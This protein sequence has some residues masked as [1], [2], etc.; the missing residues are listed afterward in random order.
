MALIQAV[1]AREYLAPR[2]WLTWC[3]LALMRLMAMLPLPAMVLVGRSVGKL[4]YVLLPRRRK[5]AETN[6][7]IAFPKASDA[8]IK[9]LLKASTENIAVATF[10]VGLTWWK[11][12]KVFSLCKVEGLD[13]LRAAQRMGHGVIILS[14]H[15]TCV[16]IGGPAF[17]HYA[18]PYVVYKSTKNKLFDAF[19][20]YHRRMFP[21]LVD[22]RKPIGMIRGLKKGYALWYLPDRDVTS[23]DTIFLPFFGVEATALTT[24]ARIARMTESPVVPYSIRRD[25]DD[26]GYTLTFFPALEGFPSDDVERDTLRINQTLEQLVLQ[27]PEQYLWAHRRYKRRPEGGSEIYSP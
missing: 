9:R 5:V 26:R 3:L 12:D 4:L 24:T 22:H 21:A 17:N 7:R 2:Y 15:F 6:L 19:M 14:A 8:E 13:D 23:K 11:P 1:N 20:H 18:P 10:E 16:E 27:N 25:S